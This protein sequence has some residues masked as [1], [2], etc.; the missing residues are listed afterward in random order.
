MRNIDRSAV[1]NCERDVVTGS[2][3]KER[4]IHVVWSEAWEVM[5]A[6]PRFAFLI[7]ILSIP[8]VWVFSTGPVTAKGS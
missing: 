2:V 4:S 3:N 8:S 6:T 7:F 5:E 1:A